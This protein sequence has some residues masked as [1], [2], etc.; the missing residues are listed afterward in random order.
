LHVDDELGLLKVAKQCLEL[1][2][3]FQVDTASSVE[4]A[5]AKLEKE[6]YDAVVS[7]YQMP[8][9]DGLEFLKEL[10]ENGNRTPFIMFTGKGREEVAIRALNLGANQYLNK[11]GETETVY[12]ELAHSI[13][14]L[15]KT[16]KAEQELL[17]SEERFRNLFEKSNDGLVFVDLSGRILDINQKLVH[18]AERTKEDVVGKSFLELGLISSKDVPALVDRLRQNA[19][20]KPTESF[21]FEIGE[22]NS[23]KKS[24]EINSVLIRKENM[25]LGSLVIVRDITE[26]KKKEEALRESEEKYK[27]LFESAM[28]AIVTL[29]LKGSITAVNSSILRFGYEK[30][31]LVGKNLLDF[32]SKEYWPAVM[33]DFSKVTQGEPVKN[34]VELAVPTG[35]ILVEYHAGVIVKENNV[36]G[37]Q[38]NMR[39]VT[40]R[41]KSEEL[42]RESEERFRG[43]FESIQDPVG[44]FVGREGHLI[45]Y[46]AAFKKSSGYTDEELKGKAFLDFVHPDDHA[47]VLEKYQTKYSEEELPLIYEIRGVNKKGESIPLEL[48]VS[49]YKK[50]GKVIGIEVI[51]RDLTERKK[52]EQALRES[53]ERL[54]IL[55]EN[56][57]D[58]FYVNDLG[59]HFIDGNKAAEEMTGYQKDE[60]IGKSFLQLGL[61]PKKYVPTAAKLLALNVLGRSTGPDELVLNR[62]DGAQIVAEIRTVPTRIDGKAVALG[63]ARDITERKKNEKLVSESQQKFEGLFMGNPE[64]AA[65]LD[66]DSRI[67]DI[68]PRF[69]ELFGY[70]LADV[71]GKHINDVVVPDDRRKEGEALDK[72]ARKGYVY[73]NTVRRKKDRSLV[74]VSVSAA[75]ITVGDKLGGIVAIYRDISDLKN[76]EKRLDVMNEKLRVV[77]NL[78]RHDVRNK[79]S[80][81][82]GN[83]YLLR[84]QLTGNSEILD[85]LGEM[86]TAVQQTVKIFDFAK[87]YEMLGVEELGYIDV[88][89]TVNEAISLF[90]DLK[91]VK[92]TNDCHGLIVLAD[93][94]LRQSF[95]NLIDNSL[96]YSQKITKIRVHYETTGNN[97]LRLAYEDD[98][99]GIPDTE[100]PKLFKEGYST[101]GSTGY[102]LYLIKKIMEVYGWTI[103]ETGKP[104]KG[105]QF[106]ITIPKINQNGKE[107][108]ETS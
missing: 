10:R 21:E 68:N 54:R 58:A 70:S 105:A 13:T 86:E 80:T 24:I 34:E 101:G 41:K 2:G 77:G 18:M 79:L 37:V 48:S 93:S 28:D 23:E 1:Q 26:R 69:E 90:S 19:M 63:I 33:R 43:L 20:G 65:Y 9:K 30:E 96:K 27:D 91:N 82:T 14:E 49:T 100:K 106:I 36:A 57:P 7:D 5:R 103:Q 6:R 94:L 53:E 32:V 44:I 31:D 75:P 55:F 62:K 97:E 35:K 38:I 99:V 16:R 71:Q 56:A 22:E 40:E 45:D 78:T 47:M 107:N 17:D 88:E 72:E 15:A 81:I 8:G 39:D 87:A 67:R 51:H 11:T 61:L 64:A 108:Y 25:P 98:G 74:Q 29:D 46:N 66:P 4:E 42:L 104:G 85:K 102:G 73:H 84:K 52:A 76:A 89:K 59:G 83:A 50:K 12:T 92:V 95:Y 3:P 60:L